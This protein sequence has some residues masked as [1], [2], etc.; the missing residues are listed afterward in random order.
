MGKMNKKRFERKN[1]S[2]RTDNLSKE[3]AMILIDTLESRIGTEKKLN[4]IVLQGYNQKQVNTVRQEAYNQGLEAGFKAALNGFQ[5]ADKTLLKPFDKAAWELI[6][7]PPIVL[8]YVTN[9][10]TRFVKQAVT[11]TSTR[12]SV[13]TQRYIDCLNAL[14]DSGFFSPDA[15]YQKRQKEFIEQISLLAESAGRIENAP[16]NKALRQAIQDTI[17]NCQPLTGSMYNE[18]MDIRSSLNYGGNP[19]GMKLWRKEL[20]GEWVKLEIENPDKSAEDIH[21]A[22][23]ERY[24]ERKNNKRSL[25]PDLTP[26][27]SKKAKSLLADTAI[28]KPSDYAYQLKKAAGIS[29]DSNLRG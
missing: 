12:L 1:E 24:T 21:F 29:N 4:K 15:E 10:D 13:Y 14:V 20:A 9:S 2:L 22:L 26:T 23:L 17:E 25:K 28:N 16:T 19:S 6:S 5:E 18:L 7:Y 8:G 11:G 27:D 3:Q